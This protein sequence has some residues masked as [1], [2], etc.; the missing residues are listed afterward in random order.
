MTFIKYLGIKYS[1]AEEGKDTGKWKK[2]K[3]PST[4]VDHLLKM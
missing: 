4:M 1:R 3:N 2:K